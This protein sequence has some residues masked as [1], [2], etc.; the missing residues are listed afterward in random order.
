MEEAEEKDGGV[1]DFEDNLQREMQKRMF[2]WVEKKWWG[3][4]TCFNV[5]AAKV[6]INKGSGVSSYD[7]AGLLQGI[8]LGMVQ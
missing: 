6:S 4:L 7:I 3:R 1:D 5:A 2:I 8:L